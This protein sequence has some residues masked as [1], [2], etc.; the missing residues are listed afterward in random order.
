LEGP[1]RSR[2]RLP[3]F[4]LPAFI[5]A[6]LILVIPLNRAD[7]ATPIDGATS[8]RQ[9]LN[10]LTGLPPGWQA[11]AGRIGAAVLAVAVIALAAQG[12]GRCGTLTRLTAGTIVVGFGVLELGHRWLK[13][14]FPVGGSALYFIPLLS[15]AGLCIVER[16]DRRPVAWLLLLVSGAYLFQVS[17]QH[18]SEWPDYAGARSA[19][20]ALRQDAGH[21]PVRVAASQGLDEVL[22]YYRARYAL[23]L[24]PPVQPNPRM[25]AF[26]YYVLNQRDAGLVLERYLKVLWTDGRLTLAR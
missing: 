24:W 13:A 16:L 20:K 21:R 12:R 23:R 7:F 6:F 8:L 11:T 17:L 1:R 2:R 4:W 5:S 14:P 3:D 18:Y 22:N 10:S 15:V 26:E 9:T 25:G 19:V